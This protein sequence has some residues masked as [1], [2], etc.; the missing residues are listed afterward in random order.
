MI[1]SIFLGMSLML[2]SP[3]EPPDLHEVKLAIETRLAAD[4]RESMAHD[5]QQIAREHTR[6]IAQSVADS[7]RLER[8]RLERVRLERVRLAHHHKKGAY[9]QRAE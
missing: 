2:P 4:M 8:V 3:A 7:L 5:M 9:S 1:G 6:S